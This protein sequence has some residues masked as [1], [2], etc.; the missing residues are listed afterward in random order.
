MGERKQDAEV[1]LTEA[2]EA[3]IGTRLL[4]DSKLEIDFSKLTV[5]IKQ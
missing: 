3:L 4:M 1:M 5:E 2:N